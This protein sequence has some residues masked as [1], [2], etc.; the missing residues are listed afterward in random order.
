MILVSVIIPAYRSWEYLSTC[1]EALKG[2]EFSGNEFEILVV[3]NDPEDAIPEWL[4]LPE[5]AL[6]I[7]Q[8]EPGSYA[9][10]NLG[11]KHAKGEFIAFTDADCIPD[12]DWIEQGVHLLKQGYDLVGG[13]MVFFKPKDGTNKAY[14]FESRFSFQQDRNILQNKQSIT[15]N[16]FVRREVFDQIG[17][18]DPDLLSGGDYEWTKRATSLGKTLAY[19][20]KAV[21]RHPSRKDFVALVNQKKRTSGGMYFSFIKE[22][23][24]F[25]KLRYFFW[26]LR[27]PMSILAMKDLTWSDR[28]SLFQSKWYLEWVGVKEIINL[29]FGNKSAQR[30]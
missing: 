30:E 4:V 7:T 23:S 18:F 14:L 21:I 16:L 28:I 9:A 24:F 20:E 13:K 1:L 25:K 2:Q 8:P 3:N 27:P 15:A 19:Q 11:L 12:P 22:Y 10:R 29:Y 26:I 6:L 17:L 5:N